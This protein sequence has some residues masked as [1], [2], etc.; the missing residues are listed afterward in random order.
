MMDALSEAKISITK[1]MNEERL[2]A[3]WEDAGV[4]LSREATSACTLAR[5]HLLQEGRLRCFA[6]VTHMW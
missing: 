5:K 6:K 3:M 4:N 2:A 1:Y